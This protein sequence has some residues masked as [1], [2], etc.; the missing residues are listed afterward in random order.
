MDAQRGEVFAAYY[1]PGTQN[2]PTPVATPILGQ[3]GEVLAA[4]PAN[5][6]AVFIGDGAVRYRLQILQQAAAGSSVMD[7]PAA[8]APFIAALGIARA[9]QGAAG[10]PHA[11][12]PLYVRRPDAELE[13]LRKA[14]P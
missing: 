1:A 3:A 11:L 10:P 12:Q 14:Q 4:L 7:P 8:L 9:R 2:L 6:A 5:S 13:R